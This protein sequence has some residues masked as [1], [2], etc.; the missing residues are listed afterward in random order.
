MY[1]KLLELK[2]SV[3]DK[4]NKVANISK[5]TEEERLCLQKFRIQ[6]YSV[7]NRKISLVFI[8][9]HKEYTV[10]AWRNKNQ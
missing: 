6:I 2:S 10:F 3:E 8:P 9:F 4:V 1:V 7:L 5:D